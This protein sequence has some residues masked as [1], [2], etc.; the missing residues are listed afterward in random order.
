[1]SDKMI[2]IFKIMGLLCTLNNPP[3]LLNPLI[4]MREGDERGVAEKLEIH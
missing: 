1:M 4:P 2:L 3:H